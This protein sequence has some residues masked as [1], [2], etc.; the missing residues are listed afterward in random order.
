[1]GCPIGAL[2]L[3]PVSGAD[4]KLRDITKGDYREWAPAI[5]QTPDMSKLPFK[6][7]TLALGLDKECA[8][9]SDR[10]RSAPA[11]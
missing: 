5:L 8:F 9:L 11:K 4:N 10:D 3:T 1:L 2:Y 7:G 6:W